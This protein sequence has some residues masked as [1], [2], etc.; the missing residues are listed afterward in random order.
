MTKLK[1][2][3]IALAAVL[4]IIQ[5][6]RPEKNIGTAEGSNDIAHTVAVSPEIQNILSKACNDCHSNHTKYP[7]YFNFQPVAGWLA[8]HIDEGKH[9]LNFSEFNSYKTK[10]KLHKLKEVKEEIED[11]EMPMDSY[12]WIHGNAKLSDTEKITLYKWVEES[13]ATVADTLK[14]K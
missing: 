3:G 6:I 10:R 14:I 11:G 7:W 5:F 1:K 13:S 4:I 9:H 8:H 12:L 2:A